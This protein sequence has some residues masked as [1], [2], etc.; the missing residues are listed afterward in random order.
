[1]KRILIFLLMILI[2]SSSEAAIVEK[3]ATVAV[4]DMGTHKGTSDPDFNL[5]NAEKSSSEYIIQRL[6]ER[7]YFTVKDKDIVQ[8]KLT[9]EKLNTTGLIDPDI[10]KRIGEILDVDYIIYGNVVN[11]GLAET[12]EAM[13]RVRTV[14][15]NLIIRVMDV[16]TG[17]I[18]MTV[19]GEGNSKSASV[20][21]DTKFI[22]IGTIK[23]SQ[24]SVHNALQKAAF[25][26]VDILMD[27]LYGKKQ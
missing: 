21:E 18:L 6:V 15:A 10:A 9:D 20:L 25:Q 17:R 23:V 13:V 3:N 26:A 11:V 1:M 24:M 7:K 16:K 8:D 14:K 12:A 5:L 27:R 2:C 19:K 22:M 4:M